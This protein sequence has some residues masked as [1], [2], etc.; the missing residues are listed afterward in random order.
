MML[1]LVVQAA[2][3]A[4]VVVVAAAHLA[5]GL[6][7]SCMGLFSQATCNGGVSVSSPAPDTGNNRLSRLWLAFKHSSRSRPLN[8]SMRPFSVGVP[9][10]VTSSFTPHRLV[11]SSSALE[12]NWVP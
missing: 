12:A 5:P 9:G 1:N 6:W 10:C 8:D 3:A 2:A 4:V 11:H 7:R